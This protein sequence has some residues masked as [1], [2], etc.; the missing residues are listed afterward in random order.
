MEATFVYMIEQVGVAE[1]ARRTNLGWT[2]FSSSKHDMSV[3]QSL[4]RVCDRFDMLRLHSM[5]VI[6]KVIEPTACG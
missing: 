4:N 6:P 1:V 3:M 2:V 5:D